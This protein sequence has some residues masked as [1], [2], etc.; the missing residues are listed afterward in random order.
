MG[1]SYHLVTDDVVRRVSEHG[2]EIEE[3]KL[4]AFVSEANTGVVDDGDIS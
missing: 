2:G 4:Q 1:I 3:G